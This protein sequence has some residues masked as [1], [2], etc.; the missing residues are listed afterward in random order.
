MT[1]QISYS[2]R[3]YTKKHYLY[4]QE[5]M[6]KP[7]AVDANLS[8]TLTASNHGTQI[9]ERNEEHLE[10]Q[11]YKELSFFGTDQRKINQGILAGKRIAK[12][13]VFSMLS[14]GILGLV[15]ASLSGSVVTFANS[16]N[17]LTYA[18]ISFI[19]FV[20]LYMAY[21]PANGKFHFG[22]HKVESFIALMAAMGMVAMGLVIV[23]YS[24]QSLVSPYE[25]KQPIATMVVLAS[26]ATISFYFAFQM[27]TVANK[28]NLLSFQIYAKS[29]INGSLVSTMGL[30]S[31]LV[32]TQLGFL[33]MDAIGSMV[34]AGYI[35]YIAYISFKQ[36]S[37]ILIDAWENPKAV[38]KIKKILE[39][40]ENFKKTVKISSILLRPAGTTGA[41]AEIHLAIDGSMPLTDVE[42]LCIQI[43]TAIKSR[44]SIIKRVATIPHP[45]SPQKPPKNIKEKMIYN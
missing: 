9:Q 18:L 13:S 6:D 35:F 10:Q 22:Y 34:I 5:L 21:C 4:Y 19:V 40:N 36:S 38:D 20:G 29:S 41:Y 27:R 39:E 30:F 7:C 28:Y 3:L 31:I 32:A 2:Q 1:K 26:A 44:I 33:Q 8:G 45:A 11:Q 37:L 25:I 43:E 24:F 16:M 15:I 42:L 23:Y 14:I 12:I 17:S